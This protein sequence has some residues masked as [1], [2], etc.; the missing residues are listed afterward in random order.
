MKKAFVL[1][2]AVLLVA[3]V[4]MLSQTSRPGA[5][6]TSRSTTGPTTTTSMPSIKV[7]LSS[8]KAMLESVHLATTAQDCDAMA[9]CVEPRFRTYTKQM[10]KLHFRLNVSLTSLIK[11]M[12]K[13]FDKKTAKK[14]TQGAI[15]FG[16]PSPL[17]PASKAVKGG[18]IDWRKVKIRIH[19]NRVSYT[20]KKSPMIL[21]ARK[22]GDKWYW[23]SPGIYN[24]TP[25]QLKMSIKRSKKTIN[26]AVRLYKEIETGVRNGTISRDNFEDKSEE[27]WEKVTKPPP[28]EPETKPKS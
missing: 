15:F 9:R 18:K 4:S 11:V 21:G 5:L 25:N 12:E 2:T 10:Y 24:L 1:L 3:S 26:Q 8:P 20:I 23:V 14:L 6:S 19:G 27:I 16:G 13:K 17:S 22:V 28:A 7:D